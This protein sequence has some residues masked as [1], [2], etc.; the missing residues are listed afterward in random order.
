[1]ALIFQIIIGVVVGGVVLLWVL[2]NL[3]EILEWVG[4]IIAILFLL[5]L[6]VWAF[7]RLFGS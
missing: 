2:A 6:G 3:E 5:A 1:M 7:S 4:G